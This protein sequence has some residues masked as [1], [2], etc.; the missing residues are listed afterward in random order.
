MLDVTG[1]GEIRTQNSALSQVDESDTGKRV[2]LTRTKEGE[3]VCV[4]PKDLEEQQLLEDRL[5]KGGDLV[6]PPGFG[7][8]EKYLLRMDPVRE[9]PMEEPVAPRPLS[10]SEKAAIEKYR[11]LKNS[12]GFFGRVRKQVEQLRAW[13]AK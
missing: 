9:R 1:Q 6:L 7:D 3:V 12:A 5:A 2:F 13:W 8:E 10:E 11:S 4:I